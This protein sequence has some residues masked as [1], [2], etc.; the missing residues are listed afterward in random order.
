[1]TGKTGRMRYVSNAGLVL[2]AEGESIGIDL[3]SRDSSGLYPDTPPEIRQ[4][5]LEENRR[6]MESS[7]V[8]ME[9]EMEGRL[10][11]LRSQLEGQTAGEIQQL[12][13]KNQA[14]IAQINE[15]YGKNLNQFAQEIVK[16][17]IEV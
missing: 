14:Q 13:E 4:E 11:I 10:S 5:L 6:K 12:V 17:I 16:K 2:E 9:K 15:S 8:E 3:F 1:M 7:E